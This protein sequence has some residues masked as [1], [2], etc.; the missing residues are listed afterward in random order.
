MY[1]KQFDSWNEVKKTV[2]DE[3]RQVNI[4]AG[5]VRWASLG[6]NVGSEVD[7][8]GASFTRPV[9]VISVFGSKLALVVPMSTKVKDEPGYIPFTYKGRQ[10]SLCIMQTKTI[11]QKRILDRMSKISS[12]RLT[13]YKLQIKHFFDL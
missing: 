12:A 2:N 10:V 11:S 3:D 9:L 6:V 7:G 4:R 8:K 5:E 1:I 13:E